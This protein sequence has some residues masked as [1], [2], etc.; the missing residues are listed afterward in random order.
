[1]NVIYYTFLAGW[2]A[3]AAGARLEF[4]RKRFTEEIAK[5]AMHFIGENMSST[6]VGQFTD[7]SEMEIALLQ[8]LIDGKDDEYFPIE[9]IGMEYIKWYK[10][11]PPDVGI[12]T[13]YALVDATS[14]DDMFN[15]ACQYNLNSESNG[16][17]MRCVPIAI[18][19]L[20]K[21]YNMILDVAEIESSLTH[22]SPIVHLTTGI[23]CCVL[24]HIV[25]KQLLGVPIDNQELINDVKELAKDN[26]KILEWIEHGIKLCDLS[27]YD[28]LSSVGHVKHAFIFFI[29]FLNKIDEYTYEK[30]IMETLMCGGDTDTNAKIVGSLFGAYYGDCIPQYMMEPVLNFDCTQSFDPI[31]KRPYFYSIHHGKNLISQT[32][33]KYKNM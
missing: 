27:N 12:T 13:N 32:L 5:D 1:M 4:Q 15:N 9:R 26:T 25:S 6:N 7:D 3:D 20:F 17:L 24:S 19:M 30:A 21:P 2:C 31:F 16:S 23:Y 8:G 29:Y 11:S 10:S 18:F 28:A 33:E 14:A 22:S